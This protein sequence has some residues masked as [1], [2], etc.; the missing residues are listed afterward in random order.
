V[1]SAT[2]VNAGPPIFE[3]FFGS[4]N[5]PLPSDVV[6]LTNNGNN[7]TSTLQFS[8]LYENHTGIYTCRVGYA[9]ASVL[10][11]AQPDGKETYYHNFSYT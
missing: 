10:I 6:V 5:S 3:W 9:A 1:C 2:D 8:P 4:E 7:Y 11:L